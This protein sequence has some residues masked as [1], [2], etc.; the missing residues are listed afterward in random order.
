[1]A[2][3]T[4]EDLNMTY[5]IDNQNTIIQL[6]QRGPKSIHIKWKNKALDTQRETGLYPRFAEFVSF[7]SKIAN[8][9]CDP[10]YGAP[11]LSLPNVKSTSVNSFTAESGVS[12]SSKSVPA[13]TQN[14]FACGQTYRLIYRDIFKAMK[15]ADRFH[16]SSIEAIVF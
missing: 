9:W 5:E 3:S 8:Y 6:A 14:C 11:T 15:P 7:M 13:P 10:V 2:C 16:T 12:A 1:M 4:L